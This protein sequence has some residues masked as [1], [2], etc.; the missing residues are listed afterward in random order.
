MHPII[1][2][3]ASHQIISRWKQVKTSLSISP[4][5]EHSLY[6]LRSVYFTKCLSSQSTKSPRR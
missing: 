3:I 6:P 2:R 5:A 4:I 1:I